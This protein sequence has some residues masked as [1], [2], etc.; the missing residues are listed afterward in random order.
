MTDSE[1]VFALFRT[2]PVYASEERS[3]EI[4]HYS[5]DQR[6]SQKDLYDDLLAEQLEQM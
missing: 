4:R 6:Q 1:I 2:V 3:E 5:E